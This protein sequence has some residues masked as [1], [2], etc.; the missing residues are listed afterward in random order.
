MKQAHL[1]FDTS[2]V[3]LAVK[4]GTGVKEYSAKYKGL[5]P[6]VVQVHPLEAGDLTEI[7]GL[8]VR[9][10]SSKLNNQYWFGEP[11][12]IPGEVAAPARVLQSDAHVVEG[13]INLSFKE[14][15]LSPK[16]IECRDVLPKSESARFLCPPCAVYLEALHAFKDAWRAQEKALVDWLLERDLRRAVVADEILCD[17]IALSRLA[18][19]PVAA[20]AAPKPTEEAVEQF[21]AM[22]LDLSQERVI[23][24]EWLTA[25]RMAHLPTQANERAGITSEMAARNTEKLR[26]FMKA[27]L[28][29]A[30]PL[31]PYVMADLPS[32][33]AP[34]GTADTPEVL[35]PNIEHEKPV[36]NGTTAI[37]HEEA[38]FIAALPM[39]PQEVT[40]HPRDVAAEL[41][42]LADQKS[43]PAV[44]S[45]EARLEQIAGER[46]TVAHDKVR[47][48]L[49]ALEFAVNHRE[50]EQAQLLPDGHRFMRHGKQGQ[51][52]VKHPS[53]KVE[54]MLVAVQLHRQD[55]YRFVCRPHEVRAY[56]EKCAREFE[57]KKI[58]PISAGELYPGEV[59]KAA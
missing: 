20:A 45:I 58:T 31:N 43:Q 10:T 21:A 57:A 44:L 7:D 33:D 28:R 47:D 8:I 36:F 53:L 25:W 46:A 50:D 49:E 41:A 59:E 13:K 1:Y 23:N 42:L 6:T 22:V 37:S 52:K 26:D 54:P 48:F 24:V 29:N 12:P 14:T 35:T 32:S 27:G 9:A 4:L 17:F 38:A 5:R 39:L 18:L 11:E 55:G 34:E 15:H 56:M 2:D 51:I 30:A 3:P 16:C 19:P 40:M